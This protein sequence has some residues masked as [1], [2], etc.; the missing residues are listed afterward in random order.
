MTKDFLKHLF[1]VLSKGKA[2]DAIVEAHETELKAKDERIETQKQAISF[3]ERRI[4]NKSCEDCNPTRMG[5]ANRDCRNCFWH[6]D[7]GMYNQ[8]MPK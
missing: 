8:F 5:V 4:G 2:I 3:L 1:T 6:P 7:S